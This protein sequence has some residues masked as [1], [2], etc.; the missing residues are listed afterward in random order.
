MEKKTRNWILGITAGVAVIGLVTYFVLKPKKGEP[1][2]SASGSKPSRVFNVINSWKNAHARNLAKRMM[3]QL[4]TPTKL[5]E[6]KIVWNFPKWKVNI[7]VRDR[8]KGVF[9]VAGGN[10][11]IVTK[12]LRENNLGKGYSTG[13]I[14]S[15]DGGIIGGMSSGF[16]HG[17]GRDASNPQPSVPTAAQVTEAYHGANGS[18]Q[19]LV[20]T[21]ADLALAYSDMCGNSYSSTDGSVDNGVIQPTEPPSLAALRQ[22][23]AMYGGMD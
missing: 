1:Q 22:E 18:V 16:T 10:P 14:K 2:S 13:S 7:A 21:A 12:V 19:P 6:N 4:G 9:F 8:K 17:S 11:T 3:K 5:T 15:P 20:P 23:R